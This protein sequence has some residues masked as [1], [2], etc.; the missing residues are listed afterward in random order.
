[1]DMEKIEIN[2]EEIFLSNEE[3]LI[4]GID[5]SFKSVLKRVKAVAS[6]GGKILEMVAKTNPQLALALQGAKL[7][8]STLDKIQKVNKNLKFGLNATK[9]IYSNGYKNGVSETIRKIRSGEMKL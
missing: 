1:M 8:L 9:T 2:G 3:I 4:N 5:F 6:G 7:S